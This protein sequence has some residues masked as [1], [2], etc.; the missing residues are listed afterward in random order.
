MP[1]EFL[2]QYIVGAT[3][4]VITWWLDNGARLPAVHVDAMLR[5]L[6]VNGVAGLDR[7]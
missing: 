5:R 3:M 6:A 1:R 2:V 4:A 7:T